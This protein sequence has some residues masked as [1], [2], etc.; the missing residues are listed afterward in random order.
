MSVVKKIGIAPVERGRMKRLT[1]W[2]RGF[3]L[4]GYTINIYIII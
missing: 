3:Y 2:D 1:D 4:F